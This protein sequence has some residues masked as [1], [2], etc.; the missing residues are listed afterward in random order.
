MIDYEKLKEAHELCDKIYLA[1][2]DMKYSKHDG[3][4]Y[5]FLAPITDAGTFH[6]SSFIFN[7]IDA[8]ITKLRELTQS[9]PKYKV[10]DIVWV[11]NRNNVPV[12]LKIHAYSTYAHRIGY[13]VA[14]KDDEQFYMDGGSFHSSRESLIQSQIEY[15]S[16]LKKKEYDEN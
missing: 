13:V 7:E 10:G 15:W 9:E 4:K 1:S 6:C 11:I 12:S 5:Y 16:S 14:N 8:L 2:V 3:E